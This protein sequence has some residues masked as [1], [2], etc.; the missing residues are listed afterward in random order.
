MR[1]GRTVVVLGLLRAQRLGGAGI[2]RL[3]GMEHAYSGTAIG[4]PHAMA[5][6]GVGKLASL[7]RIRLS[8]YQ[9]PGSVFGVLNAEPPSR[10]EDV[11]HSIHR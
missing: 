11:I 10:M 3:A 5:T 4:R 8:E 6:G 1:R 2:W 9:L 7:G